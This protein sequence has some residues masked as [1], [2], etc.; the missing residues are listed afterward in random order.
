MKIWWRWGGIELKPITLSSK[1]FLT[2]HIKL[3]TQIYTQMKLVYNYLD[4]N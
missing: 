3:Y 1:E 2:L 4:N